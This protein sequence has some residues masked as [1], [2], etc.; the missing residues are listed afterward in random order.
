MFA[1]M[2]RIP[3]TKG[4]A[5]LVPLSWLFFPHRRVDPDLRACS[6]LNYLLL[7]LDGSLSTGAISQHYKFLL[8]LFKAQ[9]SEG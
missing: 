3:C 6:L 2:A 7:V 8:F 4:H 5:P 1:L 9:R